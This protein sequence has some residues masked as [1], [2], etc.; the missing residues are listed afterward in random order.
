[1][2]K[3]ANP[4]AVKASLT[5]TIDEAAAALGKSKGTIRNWIKDGLPVMAAK[6][7]LL[8]SGRELR[9]YIRAKSKQSKI[10]LGTDQ[11]YCLSCRTGE[12]PIDMV[13]EVLPNNTKTDRL[14]GLCEACGGVAS[15]IISKT[16]A[17]HFATI[18]RSKK[19]GGNEAY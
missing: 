4:M 10:S 11:L 5:Y 1:M 19:G 15:R 3:R 7:P 8:I 17:Q 14:K 2:G 6:K 16:K 9:D 18:F 13:V 12:K